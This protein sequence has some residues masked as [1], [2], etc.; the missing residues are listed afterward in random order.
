[1]E[2]LAIDGGTPVWTG[3]WP[4]WPVCDEREVEAVTRVVRGGNWWQYSFGQATG[5]AG[6]ELPANWSEVGKFQRAFALRHGCRYGVANTSGTTALQIALRALG[7]QP[8][9]EVIVPAYTFIATAS[10]PALIGATPVFVDVEPDTY[11]MDPERAR[12]A[13]TGKT[14]AIVPVHLGG[15]PAS[16]DGVNA[17]AREHGLAVLEDAAQAHGASYRGK[18]CGSLGDAAAFSFQVSKNVSGGEGGIITTNRRELAE[19]CDSLVWVGRRVGDP[20]YSHYYLAGNARMTEFQGTILSVQLTRLEEQMQRRTHNARLLDRLL[21]EIEGIEPAVARPETTVHAYHLYTFRYRPEAFGGW[22][23]ERFLKALNG[24]G[25]PVSAGYGVPLYRNPAFQGVDV[26]A[27]AA[28][29]PVAERACAEEACWIFQSLLLAE[30]EAIEAIAEGVR[31]VQR[32]A[33]GAGPC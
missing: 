15:Q 27:L 5:E 31:K 33:L 22:P 32:A 29:C 8:G 1:M 12:E 26:E 21:A 2:K 3:E 13:I 4:R 28:R 24:E 25:I 11:N 9:D 16:M 6:D 30:E 14:K 17:V 18:P 10:A 20:W 19:L 7:V 23:K